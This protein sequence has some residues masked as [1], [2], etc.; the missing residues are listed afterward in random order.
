VDGSIL[1]FQSEFQE[2][3]AIL[4]SALQLSARDR[5]A[6]ARPCVQRTILE[7]EK[8][9]SPR[10]QRASIL[11][12][13]TYCNRTGIPKGDSAVGFPFLLHLL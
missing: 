13:I 5:P 2:V 7:G 4:N 3:A 6:Q 9:K 11:P 1:K 12:T 10:L 8:S